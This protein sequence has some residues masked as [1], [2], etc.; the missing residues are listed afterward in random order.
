MGEA[1]VEARILGVDAKGAPV[2]I[3]PQWTT[4]DP[5]MVTVTPTLPSM[6]DQVLITV[7]H[8]GE[9]KLT[10]KAQERSKE[11]LVIAKAVGPGMQVKI[12]Q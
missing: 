2:K 10:V 4:A 8:V 6:F 7:K 12:V 5:N 9:C 11:L 1:R 3:N